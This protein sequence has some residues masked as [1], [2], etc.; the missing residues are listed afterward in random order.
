MAGIEDL[1]G[2]LMGGA[3]SGGQG[4]GG[5]DLAQLQSLAGP[6]LE[7]INAQGG[8]PALLEKLQSGGLGDVVASWLGTGANAAISPDQISQVLSP[9]ALSQIAGQSGLS[10]DQVSA[11]I[12]QILPGMVDQLSPTGQLPTSTDDLGALLGQIP[13]G[14]QLGGLLGGLLGGK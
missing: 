4:A 6:I 7:Q 13:G 3:S 10:V 9:D 5:L 1:V 12:G 2:G 14:D 8:L 11:G